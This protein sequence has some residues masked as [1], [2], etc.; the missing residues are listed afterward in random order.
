MSNSRLEKLKAKKAQIDAQLK[1][2]QARERTQK[3]KDDT[4]RKIIAGALALEHAE[5]NPDSEFTRTMLRLI[6]SSVKADKD[7]MLFDLDSM[8]QPTSA[9][10]TKT[11]WHR[12]TRQK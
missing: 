10:S 7:R 4:R 8:E 3:R 1:A 9:I 12:V 2:A 11:L 6:Q 5:R